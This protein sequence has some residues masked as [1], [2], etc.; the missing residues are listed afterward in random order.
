M[1]RKMISILLCC[2]FVIGAV[3]G[4]LT[5]A[6]AAMIVHYGACGDNIGYTRDSDGMLTIGGTGA[7]KDYA[8][9]NSP[10]STDEYI[11]TVV[12]EEGVTSV[13]AY[14]F[15]GCKGLTSVV[16]PDSVTS[17]GG[18]AFENCSELTSVTIGRGLAEIGDD[19]FFGCTGLESIE[20]SADNRKYHSS[21]NCVIETEPKMLILGSENSIIPDDG[22]VT[23]IGDHAFHGCAGLTDI[24]IPDSVTTIGNFA[25]KGCTG[26]TSII[27]PG[28]VTS[29]G[30]SE[31][32]YS[33]QPW[34]EEVI[35]SGAF[36]GCTGLTSVTIKNGVKSIGWFAFSGCTGLTG[37]NIPG[38]VT[39]ID[40]YAFSG[41]TGLTAVTL[42]DGIETIGSYGFSGCT[43]LAGVT[44]PGS[45]KSISE[46]AFSG[47]TG[48]ISVN[49]AYGVKSIEKRAF[50]GCIGLRSINIPG[51]VA[52]IGSTEAV[53]NSQEIYGDEAQPYWKSRVV[54]SGAFSGCTGLTSVTIDNGVKSIGWFTF[55]RCSGLTS[56]TIPDSVTNLCSFAFKGC[57]GLTSITIPGSVTSIGA[58][59]PVYEYIDDGGPYSYE[60]D[61]GVFSGCTGLK[62]VTIRD[63][64]RSIGCYAFC[65]CT[66]IKSITIPDSVSFMGVSAFSGCT[67]LESAVLPK[68]IELVNRS[69]FEGCTGLA[70]I[71]IPDSVKTIGGYTFRNCTGLK[72]VIIPDSVTFIAN[73][74]FEGAGIKDIW[75]PEET[76]RIGEAAFKNCTDV[77][78]HGVE[79]SYAQTYAKAYNI[80][81]STESV[82]AENQSYGAWMK[83][84]DAQ[85][86]RVC[87]D[88]PSIIEIM[89][90][91]W[92][93]GVITCAASCTEA[94][95]KTYTCGV[96]GAKK[97]EKI[98]ATGHA[99]GSWTKLND[100]KHQRICANDASHKETADHIWDNG[101]ITTVATCTTAGTKTYTCSVCGAK[102]TETIMATGH[103]YGSWT[104]LNDTK[105]Q[106][107]CAND[108][109]HT[110]TADHIWDNG[111]ITTVATC[112]AAGTKTYT[113]SVCGAKKTETIAATGHAYGAWT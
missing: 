71:N 20:V 5:T 51:S 85:H 34:E 98:A 26:L 46:S 42:Q 57:T 31:P 49:I 17:I 61:S 59:G 53:Y 30:A 90:H 77:T 104:K 35:A 4:M 96:C 64:V 84:N 41:C 91:V 102:K 22:T 66:G 107:I 83:L 55:Y 36:C 75:I 62:S 103:A 110:E 81:F 45:V 37:V 12:I 109:S 43:G 92:D 13:G 7:M 67:G 32:V 82:P 76:T 69:V 19:A 44:I 47:C 15:S 87:I 2:I 6:S 113:C 27:I 68:N 10:F 94:G 72:S 86:Q 21:G 89:D 16:I 95:T 112:T 70:G 58:G 99:Y 88:D 105:H 3:S 78:I 60:I 23:S 79:G 18:Y 106:R 111:S 73:S 97:T 29:I 63:G 74:A 101:S 52:S 1:M 11:K 38:S 40:D 54:D 39:S 100:T 50:Y 25:F 93:D 108:A 8:R 14:S 24:T 33:N 48:L 28:S 56:V 80:P 65:G 9:N